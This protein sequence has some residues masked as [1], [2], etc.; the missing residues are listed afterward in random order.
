MPAFLSNESVQAKPAAAKIIN[1]SIIIDDSTHFDALSEWLSK[2]NANF[3]FCIWNNAEDSILYNTTRVNKLK[4]HGELIPRLAYMQTFSPS[5]RQTAVDKALT[6]YTE[7][8]GE[9]PKGIYDFIPDTFTAAYLQKKGVIY[10]QGYCFDQFNI[11]YMSMRGGFQMPYYASPQNVLVPGGNGTVILPHASWD[12][13]AS[14]QTTHNLQLHPVNLIKRIYHGSERA[15]NYFL[16][17]ID[18]SLAGSQPFGYV[19]VQFE[20]EWCY[21]EHVTSEVSN[22]INRLAFERS[23]NLWT[24]EQSALW[25]KSNFESTPTYHVDFTSPYN[26]QR[27]EW[28]FNDKCRVAR[29][30]GKVVSYVDYKNQAFDRY[31]T[32]N[33]PIN[34]A[35]ASTTCNSIDNSLTFTI[36]AL[37][38][39]IDRH[40]TS[41]RSYAYAGSLAD[42]SSSYQPN[43]QTEEDTSLYPL[44]FA[45]LIICLSSMFIV[46]LSAVHCQKKTRRQTEKPSKNKIMF[47][48][49]YFML[50]V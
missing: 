8:L 45:G 48:V 21:S 34:W 47:S 28:Y 7:A 22:W 36:D 29:V 2:T 23:Y 24:C 20:W 26:N 44:S 50:P 41:T 15:G 38:G 16:A 17:M 33:Q 40:K 3:T 6:K 43:S 27:I 46:G 9:T 30:A 12:W 11:D 14:F 37:G 49:P 32:E 1:L 35:A 25:F 19:M 4:E 42:F 39:A 10:Y 5:E 13:V 18:R 31:L